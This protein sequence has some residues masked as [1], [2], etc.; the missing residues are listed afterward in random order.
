[1]TK[2][3]SQGEHDGN[4][5]FLGGVFQSSMIQLYIQYEFLVF[6][7]AQLHYFNSKYI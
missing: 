3:L 2:L 4:N 7:N 5:T 6:G 1:M